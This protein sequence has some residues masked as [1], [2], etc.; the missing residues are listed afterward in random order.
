[1]VPMVSSITVLEVT[2]VDGFGGQ[3]SQTQSSTMPIKPVGMA[4]ASTEPISTFSAPIVLALVTLTSQVATEDGDEDFVGSKGSTTTNN[5]SDL[6]VV[7]LPGPTIRELV[8]DLA[9]S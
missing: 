3:R 1:M 9:K 5:D 4:Q 7:H 2:S 8:G 6:E